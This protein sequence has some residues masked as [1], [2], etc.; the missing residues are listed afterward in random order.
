MSSKKILFCVC[1]YKMY[2]TSGEGYKDAKVF[3]L[4]VQQNDEIWAS[5]ENAGSGMGIKNTS[6]LVLKE[7]HGVYK[8]KNPIKVQINE[9]KITGREI[10]EKFDNLS[11]EELNKKSNKDVY[12]K[13]VVMTAI[14]KCCRG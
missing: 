3:F 14:I 13:N 2:L 12:V 9:Y 7:I 8:T 5:M 6:Y 10:Y 1:I 4:K 11:E